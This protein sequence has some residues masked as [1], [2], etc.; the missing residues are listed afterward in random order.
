MRK[1]VFGR[2]FKR[3]ANER[4]ALFKNLL[5][6]LVMHERI[7]TTVEKAK[8]I[9][10]QADKLVTTAKKGGFSAYRN[11]EPQVN[12]D[13][14]VKLMNDI[15]PRFMTR[16]GGYTRIIK[17]HRRI[18]DNAAMAIIE[19]TDKGSVVAVVDKKSADKE[20]EKVK[21]EVKVKTKKEALKKK[22]AAKKPKNAST[23]S[24]KKE[25]KKEKKK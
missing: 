20:E 18:A 9:H 12:H 4:K 21:S 14:V 2:Q 15:A 6:S 17:A 23:S 11:L 1:N 7:T 16:K 13:A 25:V 24:V 5:T 8:A 22:P 3:D 19:W 10:G